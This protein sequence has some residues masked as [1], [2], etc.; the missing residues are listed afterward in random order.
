[1][2]EYCYILADEISYAGEHCATCHHDNI[3]NDVC[4]TEQLKDGRWV[5]LCC[6]MKAYLIGKGLL[7]PRDTIID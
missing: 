7:E 6:N 5:F 2:P 4:T 1:M 3:F